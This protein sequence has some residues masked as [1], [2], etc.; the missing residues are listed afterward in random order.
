MNLMKYNIEEMFLKSYELSKSD[1]EINGKIYGNFAI[2]LQD[3]F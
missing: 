1:L 3:V 2:N